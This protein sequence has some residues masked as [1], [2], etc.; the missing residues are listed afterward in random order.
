MRKLLFH[1]LPSLPKESGPYHLNFTESI[2]DF[3]KKLL[4]GEKDTFTYTTGRANDIVKRIELILLFPSN[5]KVD[6]EWI[7]DA[8]ERIKRRPA[9]VPKDSAYDWLGWCAKD[10]PANQKFGVRLWKHA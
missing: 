5:V 2:K 8:G 4:L 1:Y 9:G 10:W 6:W 3:S 7:G